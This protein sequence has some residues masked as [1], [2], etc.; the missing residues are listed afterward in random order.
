MRV[1]TELYK[2]RGREGDSYN[3]LVFNCTK[4]IKNTGTLDKY[5]EY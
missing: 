2:N 4:C 1:N 3:S 5:E